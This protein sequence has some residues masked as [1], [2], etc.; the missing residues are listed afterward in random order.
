LAHGS[1]SGGSPR[2]ADARQSIELAFG[3][4]RLDRYG[5]LQAQAFLIDGHQRRW[6]QGHLLAQGLARA[7]LQAGNGA[8]GKELLAAE[9]V[10]RDARGGLWA[11]A[12][13]AVRQAGDAAELLRYHTRFQIVEGK[14]TRV[15]RVR[16]VIYLNFGR[17][18]RRAFSAS[19]RDADR[20]MLGDYA[21]NPKGLEGRTVRVRGWIERRR[22]RP[23]IDL[24][25]AGLL[26]VLPPQ[27]G[28]KPVDR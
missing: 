28:E 20:A 6:V 22:E 13:Y 12:A 1:G 10:A 24:S 8:C 16:G 14:V 3:G 17:N 5:R 25:T 18:W 9:R 21:G 4:E 27:G 23:A 11:E 7:Y 19:L 2:R 15:A 26:E